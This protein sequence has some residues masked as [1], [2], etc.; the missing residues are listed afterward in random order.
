[1]A[2]GVRKKNVPQVIAKERSDCGNLNPWAKETA[3]FLRSAA[4][5]S[6]P[7]AILVIPAVAEIAPLRIFPFD[8]A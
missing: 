6:G 1:M 5:K 2:A 7:R 3:H 8:Q 4:E